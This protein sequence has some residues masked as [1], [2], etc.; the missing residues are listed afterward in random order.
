MNGI[1]IE[2]DGQQSGFHEIWVHLQ[3]LGRQNSVEY[4]ISLAAT[5]VQRVFDPYD[6]KEPESPWTDFIQ[7]MIKELG[8]FIVASFIE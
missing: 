3:D 5:Y 4:R 2:I 6:T 8:T 7:G 1:R